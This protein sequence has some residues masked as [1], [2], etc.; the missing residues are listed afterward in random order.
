MNT[1]TQSLE[2]RAT[3]QPGRAVP[4]TRALLRQLRPLAFAYFADRL[5]GA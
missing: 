3:A 5:I 1:S 4:R 2:A